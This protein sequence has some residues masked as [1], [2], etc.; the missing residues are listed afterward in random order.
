MGIIKNML[1]DEDVATLDF[2]LINALAIDMSWNYRLQCANDYKQNS[3]AKNK[4]NYVSTFAHEKYDNYVGWIDSEYSFDD[5]EFGKGK[6]KVKTAKVAASINRYDIVKELGKDKIRST[7]KAEYEKWLKENGLTD[8]KMDEFLDEYMQEIGSNYG[9]VYDSTD[10][11]LYV[12]D[13]VKVFAK[14]LKEYDGTTLQYVGIMPKTKDLKTFV[15]DSSA[16]DVANLVAKAYD[17]KKEYFKEGVITKIVGNIPF[18]KYDYELELIDNLKELGVKKVFSAKEADLSGLTSA[19]D[20]A[21]TTVKHKADIE[22][23]NDGIRAAAVT[24]GGGAGASA[25]FEYDFDVPVE[26]IDITFDQPYMYL[27]RDTKT[28]E[29]WFT[30]TVYAPQTKLDNVKFGNDY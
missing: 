14:D 1:N 13:D 18:F 24:V 28:G 4:E 11:K 30:G 5:I 8:E 25:S 21:I 23:S 12:D 26:T 17:I 7:V 20:T 2:A 29:V 27:I 16:E 10:F 9:K 19:K 15:S 6:T 3:D 22:F